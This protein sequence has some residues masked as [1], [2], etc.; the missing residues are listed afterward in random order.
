MSTSSKQ[1][2]DNKNTPPVPVEGDPLFTL[3]FAQAEAAL[4]EKN[5][6]LGP[7]SNQY[8]SDAEEANID[9]AMV[10]RDSQGFVRG[11]EDP[12]AVGSNAGGHK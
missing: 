4:K 1:P 2:A 10:P 5:G 8:V 12:D 7:T 3:H 6:G 11:E 9:E